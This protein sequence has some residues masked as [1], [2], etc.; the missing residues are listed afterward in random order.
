MNPCHSDAISLQSTQRLSF[1]Q[2]IAMYANPKDIFESLSKS[3]LDTQILMTLRFDF[4]VTLVAKQI[5]GVHIPIP[6]AH[7][8]LAIFT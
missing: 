7:M 6:A 4:V 8:M 5:P 2:I 3:Y 1:E